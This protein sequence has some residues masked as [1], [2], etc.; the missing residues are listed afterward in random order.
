MSFWGV[1]RWSIDSLVAVDCKVNQ[2]NFGLAIDKGASHTVVDLTVA[3]FTL[4]DVITRTQLETGKGIVEAYVFK[5]NQFS[6][7]SNSNF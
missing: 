7:S 2:H 6:A 3:G 4:N 1:Q 5:A